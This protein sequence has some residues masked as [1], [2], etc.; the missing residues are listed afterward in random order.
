MSLA[1]HHFGIV[2]PN[3]ERY[4]ASSFWS[5]DTAPV[6]DPIQD[7]RLCLAVL[8]GSSGPYIELIEPLSDKSPTFN[9]LQRG[10]RYHHICFA[11]PSCEAADKVIAEQRM[12][13]VTGWVPA[14]LFGGRK[15]RFVYSRNRE[16]MEFLADEPRA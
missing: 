15:V 2:V 5:L 7:A 12:M 4:L 14:V 10:T 6:A 1:M 13:P 8:P 16:L 11:A 9:A 3:I